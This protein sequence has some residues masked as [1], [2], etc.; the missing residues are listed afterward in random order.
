MLDV[1]VDLDGKELFVGGKVAEVV[2]EYHHFCLAYT[3]WYNSTFACAVASN[4]G[5][6][7]QHV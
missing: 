3:G 5:M 4:A 1:V 6:G 7:V 2:G